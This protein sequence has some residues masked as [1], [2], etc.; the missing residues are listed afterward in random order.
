M[1]IVP[2]EFAT[3]LAAVSQHAK[4]AVKQL[5]GTAEASV[6]VAKHGL[7]AADNFVKS[8]VAKSESKTL[9]GGVK[10]IGGIVKGIASDHPV[11]AAL[12]GTTL[13]VGAGMGARR[14]IVGPHTA[15][16]EQRRQG[17]GVREV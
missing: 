13:A 14:L 12:V 7:T 9:W 11:K 17:A 15:Q 10:G 16:V 8:E 3:S 1:S 4:E 5:R 2:A 6:Q